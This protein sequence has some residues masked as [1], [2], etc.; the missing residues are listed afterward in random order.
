ME[1]KVTELTHCVLCVLL[2][3]L[4][5]LYSSTAVNCESN[6]IALTVSTIAVDILCIYIATVHY[7]LHFT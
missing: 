7:A 3:P 2:V 5:L 6:E 1:E 4:S